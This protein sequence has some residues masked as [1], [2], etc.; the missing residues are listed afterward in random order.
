[1][2]LTAAQII[3]LS[4]QIA[5][6]PGFTSQ[7]LSFLNAVLQELAQDYDFNVIRKTYTFNFSTTASGNGYA[8]GSGPNVMPSD[9]LRL[10]RKG[11]F[12][13]AND[14]VPRALIGVEQEEFDTL[15]QQAGLQSYPQMAYVD[16]T[17]VAGQ[18]PGLYVWPPA[19]GAYPATIRYNPQMPD[20]TATTAVPWF[21]NSNYLYTRVAG[22]LMK[23]AND[24]RWQAF[25]GDV[26]PE[27]DQPGSACSLLRSYLKMKDDPE[28]AVKTV[29]L[30]R[31]LFKPNIS[32]VRNTKQIGW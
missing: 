16:V 31:R 5:K 14:Q 21:P 32:N 6:V 17:A 9:F 4:C 28:T 30:D 10:H 15:V 26:D 11:S 1:V 12:Y 19:S 8:P 23:I 24:D 22:E 7:A 3:D 27:K 29:Q 20:I 18:Q 25:L 13:N 2:A